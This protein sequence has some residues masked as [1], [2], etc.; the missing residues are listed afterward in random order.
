MDEAILKQIQG[1][2][3]LK[4]TFSIN[5]R[6]SLDVISDAA[7]FAEIPVPECKSK[8]EGSVTYLENREHKKNFVE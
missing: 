7:H 3:D 6:N 2:A 4:A 1:L 5:Y 8:L